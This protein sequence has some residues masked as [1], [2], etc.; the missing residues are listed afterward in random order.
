MNITDLTEVPILLKPYTGIFLVF[1][2]PELVMHCDCIDSHFM[3]HDSDVQF[4]D[5]VDSECYKSL[6]IHFACTMICI[7]DDTVRGAVEHYSWP[8][9]GRPGRPA[10]VLTPSHRRAFRSDPGNRSR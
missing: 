8:W 5:S 6:V 7:T 1:R 4:N 3:L 9:T 10:P 2:E